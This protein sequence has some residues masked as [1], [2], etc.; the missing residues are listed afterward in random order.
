MLQR[1]ALETDHGYAIAFIIHSTN[2]I[3]RPLCPICKHMA[4]LRSTEPKRTEC[5]LNRSQSHWLTDFLNGS[6]SVTGLNAPGLTAAG[7]SAVFCNWSLNQPQQTHTRSSTVHQFLRPQFNN[8]NRHSDTQVLPDKLQNRHPTHLRV[9]DRQMVM[10]IP[11][12]NAK[13]RDWHRLTL[14]N[15]SKLFSTFRGWFHK[16][17]VVGDGGKNPM[18]NR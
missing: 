4:R 9:P 3:W 15:D 11:W 1:Y 8:I 17:M 5:I 7:T 14:Y 2:T 16:L 6:S 12:A 18:C 13:L 10:V